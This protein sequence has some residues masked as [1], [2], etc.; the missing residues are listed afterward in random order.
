LKALIFGVSDAIGISTLKCLR[1]CDKI[2]II[3][4]DYINVAQG[5]YTNNVLSYVVNQQNWIDELVDICQKEEVDVVFISREQDLIRF[6]ENRKKFEEIGVNI[7]LP[8]TKVVKNIMDKVWISTKLNRFTPP[9][10]TIDDKD[11]IEY[12]VIVRSRYYSMEGGAPVVDNYDDLICEYYITKS[13]NIEPFIQKYVVGPVEN[14]YIVALLYSSSGDLK[15]GIV[16]QILEKTWAFWGK[17]VASKTVKNKNLF[18][19]AKLIAQNIGH[20]RGPITMTFKRDPNGTYKLLGIKPMLWES[21]YLAAY[22]GLNFPLLICRLCKGEDID[23]QFD[24]RVGI[25]SVR[26]IVYHVINKNMIKLG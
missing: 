17:I 2:K 10:Y 19:L 9:S 15:S 21:Q 11:S 16:I 24:Y 8:N 20:L 7:L 22:C 12:P 26:N 14:E 6:S 18:D 1:M 23:E 5:L 13:K 25:T 4:A 3:T